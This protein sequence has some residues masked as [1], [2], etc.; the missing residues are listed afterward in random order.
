MK[1]KTLI[2]LVLGI[3]FCFSCKK[4]NTPPVAV[5]TFSPET[6]NVD[7]VFTFDASGCHD[8]EDGGA[9]VTA[10]G[11]C[12]S[13][14][15][16]PTVL[17][18]HTVNGSG[19]GSYSGM[20]TPLDPNT[21]Y[22]IRAYATNNVGTG[23]GEQVQFTTAD[24]SGT[25]LDTRDNHVYQTIWI[26]NQ[27]WMAENLAYLP[28]VSAPTTLSENISFYY[29]YGYSGTSVTQAKA[30]ANYQ[31]YGVLYNWT[32]ASRACPA[33]WHLPTDAEWT[34]LTDWL[35]N[36]GYGFDGSGS[37]IGKSMA[38][39]SGWETSA[40]AGNIGNDQ[41]SNNSSG[42]NA[43]PGG[44]LDNLGRFSGLGLNSQFW[45]S[46]EE[47]RSRVW[48]RSLVFY[49]NDVTSANFYTNYGFSVRCLKD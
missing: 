7:T 15:S 24:P 46:T 30:T 47:S 37:D 2:L 11:F 12:W 3:F 36:N 26:G 4:E 42:F 22:K 9:S 35:T 6:G 16:D 20:I 45:S 13:K 18:E 34:T 48:Y 19:T 32:A 33:G 43:R 40:E 49:K 21:E 28:A 8:K 38:S 23:Y 29:V 39:A 1:I 14:D 25:Y 10:R 5:F 17:N 27:R 44:L 31:T 41:R